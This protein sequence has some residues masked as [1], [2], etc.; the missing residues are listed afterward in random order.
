MIYH[1]P[2]CPEPSHRWG[3]VL[4]ECRVRGFYSIHLVPRT[5]FREPYDAESFDVFLC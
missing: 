2:V 4:E 1:H 3:E 5:E